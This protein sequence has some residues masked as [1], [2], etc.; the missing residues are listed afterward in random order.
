[1]DPTKTAGYATAHADRLS[2]SAFFDHDVVDHGPLLPGH[3]SAPDRHRLLAVSDARRQDA[4]G[5]HSCELLVE[6]IT[7]K[8]VSII[9]PTGLVRIAAESESTA[10]ENESA[11][12]R[13]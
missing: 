11:Q 6:S 13:D 7:R 9:A 2:A 12:V 3:S 10:E 8:P 5:A 1:M 4:S